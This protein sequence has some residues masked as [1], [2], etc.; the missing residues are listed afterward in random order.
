MP[1]G[2]EFPLSS[3]ETSKGA[4]CASP[5]GSRP[6]NAWMFPSGRE[7]FLAIT[8]EPLAGNSTLMLENLMVGTSLIG[9]LT[10]VVQVPDHCVTASFLQHARWLMKHMFNTSFSPFT[11]PGCSPMPSDRHRGFFSPVLW[12]SPPLSSNSFFILILVKPFLWYFGF[13]VG[14]WH[15]SPLPLLQ[16]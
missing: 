1:P 4:T 12:T 7:H 3:S 6:H 5:S 11:S 2:I 8:E 13:I 14:V 16:V 15:S 10:S 9:L